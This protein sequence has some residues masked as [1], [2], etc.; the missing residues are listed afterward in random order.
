MVTRR[1]PAAAAEVAIADLSTL[2]RGW[3]GLDDPRHPGAPFRSHAW[4]SAWWNRFA[5]RGEPAVL[6]ARER[7]AVTGILPLYL[8]PLRLGGR[9]ARMMGDRFVGADYLGVL[10]RP[11]D[12]PELASGFARAIDALGAHELLLDDL[13]ADEPLLEAIGA[14]RVAVRY[15][16]PTIRLDGSFDDY[17]AGRPGGLA[18]QWRRR[19]RWLERR[20]GYRVELCTTPDE[21]ARG[22]EILF[23]LHRRRWALAGGSEGIASAVVEAFHRE[24]SAGL[25]ARG[26]ARIFVLHVEGAPRAVLYGFC[27]GDRFAFYQAGHDPDWRV[28]SVGTVLL[29]LI[30]E[31]CFAEGLAELDLLHG[32]EP[33]KRSWANDARRTMRLMRIDPGV[34]PWLRER[35]RSV[36]TAARALARRVLPAELVRRLR[37]RG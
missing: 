12:A 27:H 36:E 22:M 19:R 5:V 34:R 21:I 3:S 32:D 15:P 33:Y 37:A 10:G 31:W 9:R 8:E 35:G 30:V 13:H 16:C 2:E 26:W 25:A 24:A 11:H 4:I 23:D 14:A 28:R 7:G 17:L 1:E 18:Q 29:G 6:V 20:P